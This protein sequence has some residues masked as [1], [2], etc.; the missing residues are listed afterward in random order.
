MVNDTAELSPS[1]HED[2]IP[3]HLKI[4]PNPLR[5]SPVRLIVSDKI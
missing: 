1:Y 5:L 4:L 3:L 2:K